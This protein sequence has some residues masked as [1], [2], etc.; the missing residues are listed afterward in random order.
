[1]FPDR[2]AFWNEPTGWGCNV[3]ALYF[4]KKNALHGFV[5]VVGGQNA[6]EDSA[7]GA[8][9]SVVDELQNALGRDSQFLFRPCQ[10]KKRELIQFHSIRDKSFAFE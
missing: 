6:A 7:A 9:Q 3:F 1:M 5:T 2:T 10:R 8:T 4:S